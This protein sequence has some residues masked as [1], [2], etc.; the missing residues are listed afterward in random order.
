LTAALEE[1]AAEYALARREQMEDE[2]SFKEAQTHFATEVK[3]LK[4]KIEDQENMMKQRTVEQEVKEAEEL[5]AELEKQR[6][7]EENAAVMHEE[8]VRLQLQKK[9]RRKEKM[10]H[11][12][13][14]LGVVAGV[15]SAVVGV[16]TLN[17]G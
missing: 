2:E 1:K 10:R 16:A 13:A 11:G 3:S 17:P 15:V 14:I 8:R 9:T 12:V 7:N 6:I 5:K 4:K